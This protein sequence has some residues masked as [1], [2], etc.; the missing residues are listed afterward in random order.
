MRV[1]RSVVCV[2]VMGLVMAAAGGVGLTQEPRAKVAP[3]AP[4]GT[5]FTY[6]G[7]LTDGGSPASGSYDFRFIVYDAEIGGSQQGSI[8]YE[9]D[10]AASDG[11]FTVELDFGAGVFTGG[12]SYL[13]ISV[14][15][16]GS[17][18][19]YTILSPRQPIT[20][21]PYALH[22]LDTD[23][24]SGVHVVT[25]EIDGVLVDSA[26]Y[27][28]VHVVFAEDDGVEVESADDNGVQVRSVG[29]DGLRVESADDNGV[30]VNWAGGDGVHVADAQDYAGYFG[31]DVRV[32]GTLSKGAGG[33]QIDHPL[34]PEGKYLQHSF[35]ESPDMMNVYNG[36]V[37]LDA[38]GRAWVD[39]P[40]WFEALNRDF[41][42]QLTPI[43]APAPDLHVAERISGNRFA[44]AG[45]PPGVE[46][47]WQVT[48]I[49]HDPY[50]DANR[51]EVEVE[52][53]PEERETY[54]HPQARGVP[55]ARGLIH[56]DVQAEVLD[57]RVSER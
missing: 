48:G 27:D 16:G 30:Q 47:S 25:A 29:N 45:G 12:A 39:L 42:Y 33:F 50:A 57:S 17:T 44:I 38:S 53:P 26:G 20:P 5:S 32:T 46:V 3:Q 23:V 14:R 35:V 4:V 52:K 43:G 24:S 8:V 56:R 19:S 15:A 40:A 13:D 37:T 7:R 49:R 1:K 55:E 54:L 2:L 6:Q 9:E 22:A 21:V 51:I 10:V 18:G 11:F 34:D 28:G 31:G 36:N 41:R